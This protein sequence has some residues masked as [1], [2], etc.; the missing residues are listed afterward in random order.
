MQTAEINA[1]IDVLELM[2]YYILYAECG[3]W[4]TTCYIEKS[5]SKT[6]KATKE[7][8]TI[9]VDVL[10]A[11][12][13]GLW[14]WT[15]LTNP[16]IDGDGVPNG[17]DNAPSDWDLDD[18]GLSDGYE[19]SRNNDLGTNPNVADT[20]FDGLPDA[21][22]VRLGTR[23]NN[24]DTDQ[25]GLQ[26][27]DEIAGWYVQLP[28]EDG[29]R[30]YGDPFLADADLDGLSDLAEKQNGFSPYADNSAP[31]VL[32]N[33]DPA[34]SYLGR[35]AGFYIK[36]GDD[37]QIDIAIFNASPDPISETAVA[38][39]PA[40]LI[41]QSGGQ[42]NGDRTPDLVLGSCANGGTAYQWTFQNVHK[43]QVGDYVTT[44]ITAQADPAITTSTVAEAN[45]TLTY[46]TD[47]V[48]EASLAVAVDAEN[49]QA[50]IASPQDGAYIRG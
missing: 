19:L 13:S 29:F 2:K 14:N 5:I 40:S 27:G 31:W 11:S 20:D 34:A 28:G 39:L 42:M 33:G 49:P 3:Y 4:G 10:P 37:V 46:D 9:F 30:V 45:L 41:N 25:D 23:V 50:L 44:S 17:Y 47:K 26:D 12:A 38:C 36:P 21:V 35:P 7:P 24:A 8:V 15:A 16:D 48:A 43:L 18:D 6:I 1:Q 32:L 22:E